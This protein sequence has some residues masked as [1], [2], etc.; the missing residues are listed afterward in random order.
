MEPSKRPEKNAT[1]ELEALDTNRNV[2][3]ISTLLYN[4]G[5]FDEIFQVFTLQ[6]HASAISQASYEHSFPSSPVRKL[7][8]GLKTI[9]EFEFLSS[10]RII[11]APKLR[12]F[13]S[14][15]FPDCHHLT[16]IQICTRTLPE[17]SDECLRS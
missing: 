4:L 5:K 9:L 16:M 17:R 2:K 8:R 1:E 11:C 7:S 10:E 15:N 13:S 3:I 6:N 14:E 12:C